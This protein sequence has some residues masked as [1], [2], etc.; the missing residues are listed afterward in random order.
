MIFL[1]GKPFDE[2]RADIEAF[3]ETFAAT[4]SSESQ[5]KKNKRSN[6]SSQN[7]KRQDRLF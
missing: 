5:L 4:L 7:I 1:R 3:R 6:N 2:S